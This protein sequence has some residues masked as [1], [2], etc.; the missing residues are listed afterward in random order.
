MADT[1]TSAPDIAS[2]GSTTAA[3]PMA[4][5]GEPDEFTES[6]KTITK[7]IPTPDEVLSM[8]PPDATPEESAVALQR[9]RA[10]AHD[11]LAEVYDSH[12]DKAFQLRGS[13]DED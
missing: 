2:F 7:K 6:V 3:V 10:D 8:G 11:K 4:P 12:P 1:I 5:A 9:L 13:I